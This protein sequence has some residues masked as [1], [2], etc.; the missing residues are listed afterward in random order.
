MIPNLGFLTYTNPDRGMHLLQSI[1][2]AVE[3]LV[4]INNG[5]LP[6][7]TWAESAE[8]NSHI[9]S[10]IVHTQENTGVATGWN[11]II[12]SRPKGPYWIILNDDIELSPGELDR[13]N[14]D[15]IGTDDSI[16]VCTVAPAGLALMGV[17]RNAVEC[18]GRF[19]ENFWPCYFEDVDFLK[20]VTA[21]RRFEL[22][23]FP[24]Y[25][26]RHSMGGLASVRGMQN[27]IEENE[28][29]FK[30]K[31]PT[32]ENPWAHPWG[33]EKLSHWHL[34]LERRARLVGY[35]GC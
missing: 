12:E 30:E 29:Y 17:K 19:D 21:S 18:L 23:T 33:G 25:S 4:V 8:A 34:D 24:G 20:R 13:F 28:R 22:A 9:K 16:A 5:R 10:V 15:L 6:G 1:D 11:R 31:W 2:C 14:S 27:C 7:E 32:P 3:N 26:S 35:L